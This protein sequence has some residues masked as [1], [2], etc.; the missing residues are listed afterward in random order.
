MKPNKRLDK[1]LAVAKDNLERRSVRS[2]ANREHLDYVC[3]YLPNRACVRLLMSCLLAKIDRKEVDPRKP[4]TEI[5]TP[6]CFSGR[7]Y[8]E[9]YLSR[10]IQVNRLPCNPTTAFLTP[11]LR[12]INRPLNRDSALIGRPRELY[13]RTLLLLEEVAL[14][15]ESA[16][17]MLTDIIRILVA[18][19]DERLQRLKSLQEGLR[20]DLAALPLSSE[21]IVELIQQHL[22]CKNS[23]R[24]PVLIIAA[25]YE[26]VSGQL[27]ER[28]KPLHSHNAADEQTGAGGDVEITLENDERVRTIYEMKQ[29]SVTHDDIDR[30][31][32]KIA[33]LDQR[34]DNYIFIT[35]DVIVREVV[36]YA[37][38]QYESTGG[39]E[40]A[41][42]DCI[43]FLRHFLHLFHRHRTA[44]LNSYQE[45]VL[46]EPDSAVSLPLKEV[47]LT[48]RQ[49]AEA[50]S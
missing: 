41:I 47:F 42:L 23:S 20:G 22:R 36:E 32:H 43:G 33:T 19:R 21:A 8:D 3:G 6:D 25:A 28:R 10:F 7:S 37:N 16:E 38:G 35:T 14:G 5:G 12:N 29:K 26:A 46:S 40:F 11:V 18:M 30:A 34:V 45:L 44:F 2:K 13:E 17:L 24:L 31:L 50:E 39:T 49:Q 27:G 1:I 48:L 15:R 9:R 4:Y